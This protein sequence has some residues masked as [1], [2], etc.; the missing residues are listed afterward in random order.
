MI[1]FKTDDDGNILLDENGNFIN[2]TLIESIGQNIKSA[3]RTKKGEWFLNTDLGL[4]YSGFDKGKK[5]ILI[6]S[7]KQTILGVVGVVS[8]ASFISDYDK[9]LRKLT[10]K[11]TI[12]TTEGKI[13]LNEVF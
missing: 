6:Y 11:A 10:I 12:N 7:I 9:N 13:Y 1:N 3:L 8:I 5:E 2:L 4:D